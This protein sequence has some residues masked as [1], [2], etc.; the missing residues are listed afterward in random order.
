MKY[1][2]SNIKVV[3]YWN[4]YRPYYVFDNG[5]KILL[6]VAR[7][8]KKLATEI[9][10]MQVDYMNAIHIAQ[11]VW[12]HGDWYELR[13]IY[14]SYEEL[15]KDVNESLRDKAKRKELFKWLRE[16]MEVAL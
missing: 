5:N 14:D 8:T 9:G 15:L 1:K 11:Y 10:K 12:E 6:S 13:D 2:Y 3:E 7:P 16:N 4:G